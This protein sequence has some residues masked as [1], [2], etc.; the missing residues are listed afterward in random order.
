MPKDKSCKVVLIRQW[1]AG[2]SDLTTDGR[3][4]FCQPCG[5]QISCDKKFQVDQHLQTQH[6]IA[7]KEKKG[8]IT[9]TLLS[10]NLQSSVLQPNSFAADLCKTMVCSNISWNKLNNSSFRGFLQKY[11][12]NQCIPDESTLRKNYLDVVY[13]STI[14]NIREDIGNNYIW[15]AIDETTDDCGRYI[16]N[17]IVGKLCEEPGKPHLLTSK[18]LERTNHSTVARFVNDSLNFLWQNSSDTHEEKLRLI[19]SDSAAYMIKAAAS[20]EVFYPKLLHFTCLAHGLNRV[21]EQVRLEF[22]MVNSII[23]NTK[24]VFVKAPLRI[25][26]YKEMLPNVSLPPEPILTRWG[27][28]INAA[29]FY[30]QYFEQLKVVINDFDVSDSA[31]I[32]AAKLAFDSPEV[33]RDLTMIEAHFSALPQ[34]IEKL[35]TRGLSLN[36]AMDL[37]KILE[38]KLAVVPGDIGQRVRNKLHDVLKRNPGYKALLQLNNYLSGCGTELPDQVSPSLVP[39]FKFAPTTSVDVERTF[40]A[41]KLILSDKRHKLTPDNLEKMLVTYCESN[42]CADK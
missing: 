11:C 29:L 37:I 33:R 13:N 5:K 23:G 30:S 20:L 25:Q 35:E 39:I 14:Q 38:E 32:G 12:L 9:Q 34:A 21:A 28:W 15:I 1:I 22:P 31:S 18:L 19:L 7:A 40:S 3:I 4:I 8:R 2:N 27:T 6:H 17:L 16:A 36:D 24:K 26:H 10:Q 41:H 42:Y